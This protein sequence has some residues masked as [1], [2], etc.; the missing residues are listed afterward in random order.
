MKKNL[1]GMLFCTGL[2][3]AV[4]GAGDVVE[5]YGVGAAL[6]INQTMNVNKMNNNDRIQACTNNIKQS[7]AIQS[8]PF[9]ENYDQ[10][11]NIALN[12]CLKNLK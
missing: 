12:K 10:A 7:G 4:P 5:G 8:R 11:M 1:I 9:L 3:A 6:V 2:F